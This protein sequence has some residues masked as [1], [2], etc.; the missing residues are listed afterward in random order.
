MPVP[1]MGSHFPRGMRPSAH[2]SH[3]LLTLHHKICSL[4]ALTTTW[5]HPP[6]NSNQ[7]HLSRCG[8]SSLSR[9]NVAALGGEATHKARGNTSP[10]TSGR[11]W[12]NPLLGCRSR[13]LQLVI[14]GSAFGMDKADGRL[15]RCGRRLQ[16][17]L[18]ML[19]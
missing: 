9:A 13:L 3:R 5:G 7:T 14:L 8:T 19:E 6:R 18:H 2:A 11:P 17:V 15:F 16:K 10:K 12:Q 1:Q 4:F